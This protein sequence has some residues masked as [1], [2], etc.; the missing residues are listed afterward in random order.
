MVEKAKDSINTIAKV[1]YVGM[2]AF[3]VGKAIYD[4]SQSEDTPTSDSDKQK[5]KQQE[6]RKDAEPVR[7][8]L[9]PDQDIESLTCPITMTTIEEPASTTYGHLYELSA[10][11]DWVRLKGCCPL[12]QQPL[13]EDQI[14]PQYGLKDTIEEMRRMKREQK[15]QKD[16][17]AELEAMVAS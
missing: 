16:R 5:K 6:E 14:Y 1:A 11:R 9:P 12:T 10:I 15:E 4:W 2:A 7:Y 13:T 3:A 17:I 8:E